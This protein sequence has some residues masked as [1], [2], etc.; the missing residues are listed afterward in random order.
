M[1]GSKNLLDYEDRWSTGMGFVFAGE[2]VV[3]R[4]K[5]LFHEMKDMSWMELLLYG[6]TGRSFNENQIRLFNGIWVLSTSYPDPR[7]WNNRVAAL[8]GTAR[9]TSVLSI[10]AAVSVSEA[11]IYG[12]KPI[13]GAYSFIVQTKQRIS[14]GENLKD[15]AVQEIKKL[16]AIPGYSRPFGN[17]DERIGPLFSLA[18]QLGFTHGEHTTLAFQIEDIYQKNR[19]R[20]KMNVAALA[21]ALSADQGLSLEEYYRYL[22]PCFIGGMLPCFIDTYNRQEGTFL[23]LSC[24]RISYE[25]KPNRTW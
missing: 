13:V 25:G 12:F 15:I 3:F 8:A 4:G 24:E 1:K 22:T 5:D 2:R 18:E 19:Y 6:I 14:K 16:R 9:S 20:L 21:A 7:I 23:P 11:K 17:S 10:G